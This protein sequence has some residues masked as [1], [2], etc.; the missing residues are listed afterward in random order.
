[1]TS[2]IVR[3]PRN[4]WISIVREGFQARIVASDRVAWSMLLLQMLL[5]QSNVLG[6]ASEECINEVADERDETDDEVEHDVEPHLRDN[7]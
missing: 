6:V 4:E 5:Q 1:M 2:V 7:G 3:L